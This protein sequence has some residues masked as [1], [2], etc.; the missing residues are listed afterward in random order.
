MNNFIRILKKIAHTK[1]IVE[2]KKITFPKV[3][4]LKYF[5]VC[6]FSFWIERKCSNIFVNNILKF[7][8][9]CHTPDMSIPK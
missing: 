2:H 3:G 4:N 9:Y 5:G 1:I 7:V 8:T 6:V